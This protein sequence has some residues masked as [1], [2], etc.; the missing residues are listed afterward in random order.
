MPNRLADEVSYG[1]GGIKGI[2]S[3]PYVFDAALLASLGGYSFRYDQGVIS[4]INVMP[5]FHARYSETTSRGFYTGFMTVV[6][7]FGTFLGYFF[8]P[9]LADKVSKK[10]A[11]SIAVWYIS[12]GMI[13][14]LLVFE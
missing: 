10:W 12:H 1:P 5:Q 2:V 14:P 3:S 11:L 7:E 4:I 6:L 8:M 9:R 13:V